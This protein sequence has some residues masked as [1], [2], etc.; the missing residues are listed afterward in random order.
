MSPVSSVSIFASLLALRLYAS[1]IRGEGDATSHDLQKY[2][3]VDLAV[4]IT[5]TVGPQYHHIISRRG[6]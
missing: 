2:E 1:R 6:K 5:T 3:Y 4:L